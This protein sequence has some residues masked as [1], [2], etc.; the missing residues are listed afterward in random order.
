MLSPMPRGGAGSR[1]ATGARA[2][3]LCLSLTTP[4]A[5]APDPGSAGAPPAPASGLA[6]ST[7]DPDMTLKRLA[8]EAGKLVSSTPEATAR[9]RSLLRELIAVDQAQQREIAALRTLV[10][11]LRASTA[12]RAPL[13]PSR[14]R[15]KGSAMPAAA[16]PMVAVSP[17]QAIGTA[18]PSANLASGGPFFGKRGLKK[19][20]RAGCA[21]GEKIH[22]EDRVTFRS[23]EEAA[24]AGYEPCK[25][26]R[27]GG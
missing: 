26:C 11:A 27:P 23:L 7:A 12:T 20:H 8:E 3:V 10:D 24:A 13:T 9:L 18:H 22:P 1:L 6:P 16:P 14:R 25:V 19:V 15:A 2:L 17:G 4:L 21:F 5:A